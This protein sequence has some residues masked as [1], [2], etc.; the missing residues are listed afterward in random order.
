MA[1]IVIPL[2]RLSTF[3]NFFFSFYSQEFSRDR[4]GYG[5]AIRR[6]SKT[7]PRTI[8]GSGSLSRHSSCSFQN[9]AV[10]DNLAAKGRS[11]SN[12]SLGAAPSMMS[13]MEEPRRSTSTTGGHCVMW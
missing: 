1:M 9:L 8:T 12:I 7:N 2:A 10:T 6:K 3:K 13:V 4:K 5:V 11:H